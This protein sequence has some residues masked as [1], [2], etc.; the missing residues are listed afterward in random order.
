MKI[1]IIG[2]SSHGKGA[3]KGLLEG[4]DKLD[5]PLK[6]EVENLSYARLSLPEAGFTLKPG[7]TSPAE[8]KS[9]AVLSRSL[10]SL[11][12]IAYMNRNEALAKVCIE[13]AE[14]DEELAARIALE[15]E[16]VEKAA[17]DKAEKEDRE[18]KAKAAADEKALAAEKAAAEKAEKEKAKAE[19]AK[20]DAE[21]KAKVAEEA[22]A[23]KAASEAGNNKAEGSEPAAKAA[24]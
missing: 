4:L 16:A 1:I 18:A 10:S 7:S 5:Y 9:F 24:E 6:V 22:A 19:K 11:S 12:A 15:S 2:A 20:A 17:K 8:F 3:I 13:S 23:A 21:A 14:S